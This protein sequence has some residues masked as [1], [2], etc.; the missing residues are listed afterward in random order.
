MASLEKYLDEEEELRAW[1][2][3]VRGITSYMA[4][5]LKYA[6]N[7][8]VQV[9]GVRPGRPAAEAKPRLEPE[10]V[11]LS[12]NGEPVVGRESFLELVAKASDSEKVNIRLRRGEEDILTVVRAKKKASDIEGG[13][14]PKAWVGI[15]TQVLTSDVAALLSLEKKK[16]FRVTQVFPGTE[17]A[18]AG[19][20]A[21]DIILAMNGRR[22][23]ASRV[24][25]SEMLRRQVE[26]LTIGTKAVFSVVRDGAEVEISI[27]LEET[28]TSST[29]VESAKEAFL[30]F[31]VR[32]ITFMDRIKYK[33]DESVKGVIV[34][35]STSGGWANLA[36]LR[37][38]DLLISIQSREIPD[39]KVFEE[40][41]DKIHEDQPRYVKLFIRRGFKTVFLFVEPDWTKYEEEKE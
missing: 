1:G 14:L 9:T 17:A 12:I 32:E 35:D 40:V 25:D 33:W 27:L 28:P 23:K 3:T 38:K 10:D 39:V 19:L 24:Q 7:K 8:G 13:E 11:I 22:L 5:A 2:V 34:G 18:K 6:D 20:K 37:G 30:E 36:G 15:K 21:G 16:G 31:S 29:D 26:N 4:L 41:M